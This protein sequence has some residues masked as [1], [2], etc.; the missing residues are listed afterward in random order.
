MDNRDNNEKVQ[1]RW[2]LYSKIVVNYLLFAALILFFVFVFPKVIAFMWPFVVGWII[3]MIANPLVRFLEKKLKILRRHGTAIVIISV[4][5]LVIGLL[6]LLVY[7]LIK[8][9][10]GFAENLPEIYKTTSETIRNTFESWQ[11]NLS[12]LPDSVRDWVYAATNNAGK[13]INNLVSDIMSTNITVSNAGSVVKSVAEGLLMTVITI[14]LCYFLT[15][16]HDNIVRV[17]HEKMPEGL[18]KTYK[19]VMDNIANA[20][21]GYF[22]AQFKIMMCVFAILTVGLMCLS[23]EYAVWIALIIA[24]VDFLPVFGSGAIIWPWCLYDVVAGKYVHAIVLF[25]LYLVCQA[26]R[27]FLQPKMVADSIGLSPLATI[28]YMFI[29]YRIGGVIGMII[30]IPIGMIIS[31]FYKGGMFDNLIRGAKIIAGDFNKWRK[32]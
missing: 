26:A 7:V 24:F 27:Q 23:V 3:A 19:M 11:S 8:Q 4:L 21:V 5:V 10:I 30:A 20:L 2:K 18:K 29:G 12:I 14:L 6:Y 25:A 32:F 9:G 17:Y 28:F 31:T 22:K 1:T 13:V 15:A 16:E